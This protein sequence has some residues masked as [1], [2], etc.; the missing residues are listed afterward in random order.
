MLKSYHH[1]LFLLLLAFAL[2]IFQIMPAK[3]WAQ[4]DDIAAAADDDLLKALSSFKAGLAAQGLQQGLPA[5]PFE[6]A[7]D[8]DKENLRARFA[9][10]IAPGAYIYQ[11]SLKVEAKQEGIGKTL[12]GG[13]AARSVGHQDLQGSHLVYFDDLTYIVDLKNLLKVFD[14]LDEAKPVSLTFAYQG[15]SE[16]GICYPPQT[17][18]ITVQ[19][20]LIGD[21]IRES[22]AFAD[23]PASDG[24]G[25]LTKA[26]VEETSEAFAY[27]NLDSKLSQDLRRN[28]L[29]GMAVCFL[30][31][32]GLNLTP[33]VLPM[34]P[35]FSAMIVGGRDKSLPQIILKNACYALGLIATYTL[36]GLIFSTLGAKAQSFLQHPASL[37]AMA[38]LLFL[39]ALSCADVL[40]GGLSAKFSSFI[41]SKFSFKA[42]QSYAQAVLLGIMSALVAT[43]CTSAPLAG[44]VI[45]TA[46][47]GDMLK[48]SATFAAI[49]LGMATPLFIIGV[50]GRNLFK[51]AGRLSIVI[52]K[53]MAIPLFGAAVYL[54]SPLIAQEHEVYAVFVAAT[55]MLFYL[56]AIVIAEFS[57][58]DG[59][60]KSVRY[61]LCALIS[62]ALATGAAY[63]SKPYEYQD[64]FIR[65]ARISDLE[66][67]RG[68]KP[69]LI[70]FTAAW[71]TN[72]KIMEKSV[73]SQDWMA[74]LCA[75]D[76]KCVKFDLTDM[77]SP[78]SLEIIEHFKI[79]GI[80]FLV[81][82]DGSLNPLKQS[83]GLMDE[84][85]FKS[86]AA[87]QQKAQ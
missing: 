84:E 76:Y 16:D 78:Q 37:M 50:S 6:A 54:L 23:L 38:L 71:C 2:T 73:F 33:C 77:Q 59:T 44:A 28:L 68:H 72:C 20:A 14:S 67:H 41:Q 69:L 18:S 3:A 42:S 47:Q 52:K 35:I 4:Q 7:G 9:L 63:L 56:G 10:K 58:A 45:Y 48:G 81:I 8:I 86:F 26:R 65:L 62:L 53:F 70:D 15:C 55:V 51:K 75:N 25:T 29:W 46:E 24:Y 30:L 32:I 13:S 43:P 85:Q 61:T 31:G 87:L 60:I 36:T 57:K 39:C 34:L 64:P 27:T 5:L 22:P 66:D 11:E 12:P 17:V 19:S 40:K 83:T 79:I 82:L 74:D 80:P 49:G 21:L 1:T